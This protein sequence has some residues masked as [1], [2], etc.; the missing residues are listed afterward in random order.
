VDG[1]QRLVW[2][3]TAQSPPKRI[4][5]DSLASVSLLKTHLM[6][7]GSL[8]SAFHRVVQRSAPPSTWPVEPTPTH[9]S[10]LR[11][12]AARRRSR[13]AFVV[14]H[15]PDGLLLHRLRELVASRCRPW[16]SPGFHPRRTT[17]RWPVDEVSQPML[18]PPELSPPDK[19]CLR[20][21]RPLPPRRYR[22]AVRPTSRPCSCRESV[23]PS[24][25]CRLATPVALLGFPSWSRVHDVAHLPARGPRAANPSTLP[26]TARRP[27]RPREDCE[28]V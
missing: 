28:P 14:S 1:A 16:G 8:P 22:T 3:T 23:A 19:P 12:C 2:V 5:P 20:H 6:S 24:H 25:R 26:L 18:H 11:T 27:L 15:H 13:S 10:G 9:R 7:L 4:L 21:R 17:C